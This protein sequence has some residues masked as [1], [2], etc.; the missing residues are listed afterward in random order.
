MARR[1]G[2]SARTRTLIASA[3]G[4]GPAALWVAFAVARWHGRLGYPRAAAL[5]A[6]TGLAV[7]GGSAL[8]LAYCPAAV[9]RAGFARFGAWLRTWW[10]EDAR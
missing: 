2:V 7:L 8:F 6:F 5:G 10:D 3:M 9:E 1:A 4:Y